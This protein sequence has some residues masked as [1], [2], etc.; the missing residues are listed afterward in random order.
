MYLFKKSFNS[1]NLN[2]GLTFYMQ[3][4]LNKDACNQTTK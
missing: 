3:T 4:N 2:F 1:N